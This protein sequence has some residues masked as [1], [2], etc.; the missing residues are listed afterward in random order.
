[1]LKNQNV[2]H[3]WNIAA[4]L[5]KNFSGGFFK[6]AYSYGEAKNT[7]DPGSIAFGSW[8]GNPHS[9]DP[10]NPGLGYSARL[11]RPPL[12]PR[13]VVHKEYF[14]FGGDDVS[15]FWESRTN[16]N[17]QLHVRRRANNDGA[18]ATT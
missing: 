15:F 8:N 14:S 2:G 6:G 17:D 9:G 18:R 4:S 1:M 7:V 13:R 5:D 16:G 12:L 10:N 11:A 3:S